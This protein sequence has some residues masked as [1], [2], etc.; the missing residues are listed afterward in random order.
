MLTNTGRYCNS[1]LAIK[2]KRLYVPAV[3]RLKTRSLP[4]LRLIQYPLRE[5]PLQFLLTVAIPAPA[6]VPEYS[7]AGALVFQILN[8][9][10]PTKLA[11]TAKLLYSA[12]SLYKIE[13]LS[14]L[15]KVRPIYEYIK[16]TITLHLHNAIYPPCRLFLRLGGGYKSLNYHNIYMVILVNSLTFP[17]IREVL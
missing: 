7:K 6:P 10:E 8:R 9:K 3:A 12:I 1:M 17:L 2:N 11:R 15:R 16:H 5:I 14:L 13:N 4:G